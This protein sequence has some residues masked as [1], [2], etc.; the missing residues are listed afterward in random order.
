MSAELSTP[1]EQTSGEAAR[2]PEAT[3][4]R[5]EPTNPKRVRFLCF[6]MRCWL[7][8]NAGEDAC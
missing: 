4:A 3:S 7:P 8:G 5:T 2:V 1:R 6:R